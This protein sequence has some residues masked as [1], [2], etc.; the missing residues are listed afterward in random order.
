MD[1]QQDSQFDL[2]DYVVL[3]IS[4]ITG[5]SV[6]ATAIVLESA[7]AQ[8]RR[9][10]VVRQIHLEGA[11]AQLRRLLVV[12]QIHLESAFAQL[13]HLLVVWWINLETVCVL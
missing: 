11:L 1:S 2:T 7:L 4:G 10:L 3:Q 13:R 6:I 9:L 5:M 8:L 12:Q